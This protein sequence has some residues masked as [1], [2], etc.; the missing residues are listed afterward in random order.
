MFQRVP[1]RGLPTPE[2]TNYYTT[3]NLLHARLNILLFRTRLTLVL[4]VAKTRLTAK[5]PWH[6]QFFNEILFP[7]MSVTGGCDPGGPRLYPIC[8][9][10]VSQIIG[11][12]SSK[13]NK[14]SYGTTNGGNMFPGVVPAPFAPVKLGPDMD[15]MDSA[16][17]GYMPT[18]KLTG[19]SLMHVSGTGGSPKY[20][21]VSQLPI[22]GEVTD[23]N[24]SFY[25]ER[26]TSDVGGVGEYEITLKNGIH[27]DLA[28][29]PHVGM[30]Q[31]SFPPNQKA[32]VLVDVSHYLQ[33][34][35]KGGLLSQSYEE[36]SIEIFP[37]GH[38]EGSGT[39]EGGWN[40]S[41]DWKVYFCGRFSETPSNSQTFSTAGNSTTGIFSKATAASST[42]Q[43]GALFTFASQNVTSRVSFSFLS[44]AK[45]CEYIDQEVPTGTT[46]NDLVSRSKE[47]WNTQVFSKITT[48]ER[49]NNLLGQLYSNMYGMHILPT[50][51]TGENP[52]SQWNAQ[53]PYY[54]D[55][56]TFWD[57][58]RCTTPLFHILQPTMYEE[59][60]RSIV[61]V[62]RTEGY[63]PDGRSSNFNGRSQGGS[64]ADN[65]LADAFVKG[66]KGKL[67][68]NLAY[69]AMV[70]DA[71]VTPPNNN[72]PLVK[73]SS[74][75][76]GRG[77]LPDWLK[78]GFITTKFTRSVT[79]AVEYSV[80]DFGLSQVASGLGKSSDA[81]LYLSRS[82]NWRNHWDPTS[83]SHNTIGFLVPRKP[84]GSFVN[85]NPSDCGGCYWGEAYYEGNPWEYTVN[86]HHD[87]AA[88]IAM[89]SNFT[90]RLDTLLD[91]KNKLIN[92]GNE[93]SFATPYLYNFVNQQALSVRASRSI[94]KSSYHPGPAGLPGNSDA[95]A[96]QSWWLWNVIGLYP[97][98]GQTTFLIGSPWFSDLHI[99]L[100]N[101]KSLHITTSNST[102]AGDVGDAIYVQSLKVNGKPWNQNWLSYNDVFATGGTLEFVM[103]REMTAW[104]EN[105]ALPPSPASQGEKT[106]G[107]GANY[108]SAVRNSIR[109]R[110]LKKVAIGVGA[111]SAVMVFILLVS[112]A[113]CFVRRRRNKRR[114]EE[115]RGIKKE[116]ISSPVMVQ[117]DEEGFAASKTDDIVTVREVGSVHSENEDSKKSSDLSI[118]A[119]QEAPQYARREGLRDSGS[120][121]SFYEEDHDPARRT[122]GV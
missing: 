6:H 83:K 25:V 99:N 27:I 61:E 79:R 13:S 73:D 119:V 57:L 69:A 41:P 120:S 113:C 28:G 67:D 115:A 4:H 11:S 49:D 103:G 2:G 53:V 55:I 16:K 110:K 116:D 42:G 76:Q 18:G 84:D 90:R 35:K 70:K 14:R 98:T 71:E 60:L 22:V 111:V 109:E 106:G 5:S 21:T 122:I 102:T 58:F 80:N 68:W 50:N 72:D 81:D 105:G 107:N 96:M 33:T 91:P 48:T 86:P 39:Y 3:R 17:S 24:G 38:Y 7:H 112:L 36:G 23:L 85:Q 77:A 95:G 100:P 19:L 30:L 12:L 1:A 40:L 59:L 32:N 118:G 52:S 64:N 45:A 56:Y 88:L 34:T 92:M 101:D 62:Y 82:R 94:A 117:R 44:A 26:S 46:L 10:F 121:A 47:I 31:Y 87:L 89:D 54:D 9:R 15:G 65:V 108:Y 8:G 51:R 37:D 97:L 74:T 66:V 78:L 20:G 114:R 104:D 63:L 29:S 75:A 43:T 93:P